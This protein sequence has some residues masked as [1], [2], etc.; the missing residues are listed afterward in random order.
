MYKV[1]PIDTRK[2]S[3]RGSGLKGLKRM[4]RKW[5]TCM[6]GLV[7]LLTL[8]T[9]AALAATVCQQG[10]TGEQVRAVQTRLYSRAIWKAPPRP[11]TS[12][13]L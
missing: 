8:C 13:M 1:D 10:D 6:V 12:S 9:Q 3:A 2:Y 5:M 7:L 4:G 11:L